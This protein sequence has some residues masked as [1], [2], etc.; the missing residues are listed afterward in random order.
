MNIS[1]FQ[2]VEFGSPLLL[3]SFLASGLPN[4]AISKWR[5]IVSAHASHFT[6][7]S[8]GSQSPGRVRKGRKPSHNRTLVGRKRLRRAAVPKRHPASLRW[9]RYFFVGCDKSHSKHDRLGAILFW[10]PRP[11]V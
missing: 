9:C 2:F 10:D 5:R 8:L 11:S 1:E 3:H 4:R 7:P 6:T